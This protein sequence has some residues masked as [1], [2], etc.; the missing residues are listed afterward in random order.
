MR[1]CD[2]CGKR[3]KC[4]AKLELR[5]GISVQ[6]GWPLKGAHPLARRKNRSPWAEGVAS[7]K[8]PSWSRTRHVWGTK[9]WLK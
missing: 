7:A 5:G 4:L 9:R 3:K 8:T 6:V 2:E 1:C